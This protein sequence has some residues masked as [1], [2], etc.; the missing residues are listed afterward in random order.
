ML[1]T[2]FVLS[3]ESRVLL[4]FIV[5]VIEI[6]EFF[7]FFILFEYHKFCQSLCRSFLFIFDNSDNLIAMVVCDD[8]LCC[9]L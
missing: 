7:L 1:K 4:L 2:Y 9:Y 6:R 8:R 3:C 5:L